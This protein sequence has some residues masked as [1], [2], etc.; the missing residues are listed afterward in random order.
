MIKRFTTFLAL[1]LAVSSLVSLLP[2]GTAVAQN[3]HAYLEEFTATWCGYCVRG[4]YAIES[5]KAKYPG[6]VAVLSIHNTDPMINPQGDS[7]TQA[8]GFPSA[9]RVPGFPDSWTARTVEGPSWNVDPSQW[10]DGIGPKFG[11]GN[12]TLADDIIAS[13]ADVS[14]VMDNVSYNVITNMV[15]AHLTATFH[16]AMTG[17]FRFNV[18]VTEDSLS[19]SDVNTWGQHNYYSSKGSAGPSAPNNPFY[20]YPTVIPNWQYMDVFREAV[21]GVKGAA[22]IIPPSAGAN[23]SYSA[24]F[25]FL[26]PT[27]VVNPNHVHIIGLV[28]QFSATDPSLNTVYDAMSV[29]LT[30]T[31]VNVGTTSLDLQLSSGATYRYAKANGD[32]HI[33]FDVTNN[34]TDNVTTDFQIDG[35]SPL[36][37]GCSASFSPA[38]TTILPGTSKT[39]TMTI[40]T[41]EQSSYFVPS[42]E[43]APKLE[44]TYLEPSLFRPVGLL[45]DNTRYGLYYPSLRSAENAAFEALPDSMRL[46][47]VALPMVQ[48]ITTTFPASSMEV[49]IIMNDPVLDATGVEGTGNP[50]GVT[51]V[52]ASVDALLA[53][54]KKVF[55][56]SPDALGFAYGNAYYLGNGIVH[57]TNTATKT[58]AV[59]AFFHD[60]LG[61][62]PM[63][64]TVNVDANG[65]Y[66]SFEVTGETGDVIGDQLDVTAN[67][68]PL[69][70]Y[71]LQTPIFSLSPTSKSVPIF[72]ANATP[73][74]IV[75]VRYHSTSGGKLVYLSFSLNSFSDQVAADTVFARSMAWLLTDEAPTGSVAE[76]NTVSSGISAS[77][78]PFHGTTQVTYVAE[79]GERDVTF[80]AFDV[81][82]R[83]VAKLTP[84][85]VGENAY[86]VTLDGST[87]ADGTYTVVAHTTKGTHEVRVVNQR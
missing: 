8:L 55:I 25:S 20:S 44:N 40:T 75:G 5:L 2:H 77:A 38:T 42:I 76:L 1:V 21:A 72:Y 74:S 54:G 82:G 9:E 29:K 62:V 58:K 12:G 70:A 53:N 66:S 32:T 24:T 57:Y 26:L 69:Y 56:S 6:Q 65:Y 68:A 16:S 51:S 28:H 87:L 27:N 31:P 86:A 80:S 10:A 85:T 23:A 15:T 84:R 14:I 71:E 11:I 43:V 52:M 63:H 3:R 41:P 18:M 49:A 46:H 73:D 33:D 60:T 35:L 61:I 7:L 22:G 17:D 30:S 4:S 48:G 83:E 39:V 78:N 37:A 50:Y 36:P 79:A 59:Q 81:L 19:G 64:N 13:T 67:Q 45:S 47:A 34:G